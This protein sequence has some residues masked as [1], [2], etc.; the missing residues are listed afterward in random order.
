MNNT[1]RFLR[2]RAT[3][4]SVPSQTIHATLSTEYWVSSRPLSSALVDKV[5]LQLRPFLLLSRCNLNS[6]DNTAVDAATDESTVAGNDGAMRDNIATSEHK[7][8]LDAVD[9]NSPSL[10]L[11]SS[12]HRIF[13][14][15]GITLH[16]VSRF[17]HENCWSKLTPVGRS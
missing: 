4:G 11:P 14:E 9:S 2:P 8:A 3:C 6:C 15:I 7:W 13:S 1:T 17:I 5:Q 16:V 10:P 12:V